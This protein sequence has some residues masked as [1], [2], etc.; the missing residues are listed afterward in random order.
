MPPLQRISAD[1]IGDAE[2]S[3]IHAVTVEPIV[4]QSSEPVTSFEESKKSVNFSTVSIREFSLVVG[5]HPDVKVGPPISIG[6]QFM[7]HDAQALD[8]Y[9]EERP[10]RILRRMTSITRK[11]LLSNE[12]G[13]PEEEIRA[14][15]KEVQ[16]ILK[17]RDKSKRQ[18]KLSEKTEGAVRSARRKMKKA[19]LGERLMKGLAFAAGAMM[20]PMGPGSA[21]MAVY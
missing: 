12:F 7:E 19:L 20:T 5:D 1:F 16:L 21:G 2:H 14:A 6:W 3:Q 18:S 8:Q 9:E 4:K 15:E 11:N 10:V 17:S 13:I